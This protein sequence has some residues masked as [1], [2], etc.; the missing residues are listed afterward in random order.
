MSGSV[1]KCILIGNLGREPERRETQTGRQIVHL[2]VATSE[3]WKDKASGEWRD[4]TEWHRVVVF[5]DHH[6]EFA[7]KLQKGAKVYIEG[8]LQ[9]RKWTDKEGNEKYTTEVVVPAFR[10][11]ITLLDA[12]PKRDE[13][14]PAGNYAKRRDPP[15]NRA[16]DLDD[17][18]PF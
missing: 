9:T 2:S 1:N 3:R 16:R 4:K 10:G 6:A 13:E 11:E 15:A 12:P 14:A 18:I 17:D 5:N 8:T 7:A